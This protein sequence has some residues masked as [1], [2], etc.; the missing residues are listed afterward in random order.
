M[1]DKG[2]LKMNK[3]CLMVRRFHHI[4]Y[5]SGQSLGETLCRPGR[6]KTSHSIRVPHAILI[7]HN[8]MVF[9]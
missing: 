1:E 2:K 9:Q 8:N 4:G 5:I 6:D 3:M 7:T